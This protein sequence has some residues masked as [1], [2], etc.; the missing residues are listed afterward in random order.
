MYPFSAYDDDSG[1]NSELRYALLSSTFNDTL[2]VNPL[3]GQLIASANLDREGPL[4]DLIIQ[5][6][7]CDGGSVPRCVVNTTLFRL[8]DVNDNPPLLRSGFTYYV[9]ERTPEQTHV[10][11]FVGMDPDAGANGT[12]RYDLN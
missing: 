12:I 5:V 7:V 6:Y 9:S 8:L 3:S 2:T 11:S 4:Q 10:F 1:S